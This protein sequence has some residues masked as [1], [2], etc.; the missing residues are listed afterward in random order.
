MSEI[1]KEYQEGYRQGVKDFA[2][3]MKKYYHHLSGKTMSAVVKYVLTVM[4]AEMINKED[5]SDGE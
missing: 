2:E 3:R 4:E 5:K 1:S